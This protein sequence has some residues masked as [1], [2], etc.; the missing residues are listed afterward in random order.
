MI[1]LGREVVEL[2]ECPYCGNKNKLEFLY[3]TCLGYN[4]FRCLKCGELVFLK[5]RF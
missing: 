4:A 2:V 1:R 5:V 3:K